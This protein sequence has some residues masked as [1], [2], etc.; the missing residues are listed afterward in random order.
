MIRRIIE[1]HLDKEVYNEDKCQAWIDRICEDCIEEL[2]NLSKDFKYF[3]TLKLK[4]GLMLHHNGVPTR[5]YIY[6]NHKFTLLW[7]KVTCII[8]QVVEGGG[9][10][11][12]HSSY[13]NAKKDNILH[14]GWTNAGHLPHNAYPVQCVVTVAGMSIV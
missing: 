10:H 5:F 1:K 14:V 3:G 8:M 6:S 2:S 12:G 13:W 7:L 4:I 11:T 9:I